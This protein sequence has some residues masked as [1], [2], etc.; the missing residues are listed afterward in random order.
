[1]LHRGLLW[2]WCLSHARQWTGLALHK[3]V[4]GLHAAEGFLTS[5]AY[6]VDVQTISP[7]EILFLISFQAGFCFFRLSLLFSVSSITTFLFTQRLFFFQFGQS[8]FFFSLPLVDE[9]FWTHNK[10]KSVQIQSQ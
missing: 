9:E 10:T 3:V 5:H 6:I 4:I 1:M 2:H 7:V 8:G